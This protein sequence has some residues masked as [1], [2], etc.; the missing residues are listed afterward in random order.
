MSQDGRAPADSL[1]V[2]MDRVTDDPFDT[3]PPEE[4]VVFSSEQA[5]Q[6]PPAGFAEGIFE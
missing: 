4:Q 1:S 5:A 2:P 3:A 6:Q